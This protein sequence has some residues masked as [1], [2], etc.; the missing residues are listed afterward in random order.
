MPTRI[1]LIYS[2]EALSD[3][4]EIV[5][6]HITHVGVNSSRKIYTTIQ[7]CIKKLQDFPLMGQ[8]HPD[9]VLAANGYRKLVTKVPYVCIYRVFADHIYIY[10]I[11]NGTTDYPSLLH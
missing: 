8:I 10:R 3:L 11:V 4:E 6:F 2:P 7:D 9:P 5:K 1:D